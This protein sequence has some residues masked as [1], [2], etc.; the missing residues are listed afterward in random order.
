VV[1][2]RVGEIIVTRGVVQNK[3]WNWE[4]GKYVMLGETGLTQTVGDT[5]VRVGIALSP[6]LLMLKFEYGF[7]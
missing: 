5:L 1:G 7:L 2:I 3:E 4:T 6:T